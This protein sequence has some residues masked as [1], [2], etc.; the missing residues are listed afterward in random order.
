MRSLLFYTP[1][2]LGAKYGFY[3][4]TGLVYHVTVFREVL[5]A[6]NWMGNVIPFK[7][8]MNRL[9]NTDDKPYL[10]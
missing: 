7:E 6:G 5:F 4:E 9:K 10:H 8:V 2:N 3:L 1:I